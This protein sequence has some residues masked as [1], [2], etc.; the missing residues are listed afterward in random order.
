MTPKHD[1]R[2]NHLLRMLP[3]DEYQRLAPHLEPVELT[4]GQTLVESGRMT[5]YAYF[6]VNS[7]ISLLNIMEDGKT[8]EVSLVGMEGMVGLSLFMGGGSTPS[9]AI[10]Q[11][12]GT[13]Y[14]L[15]KQLLTDEFYRAGLLQ[16]MLLRFT[17]A[18]ITQMAHTAA[19]NRYHSVDQ[20]FCR[21]LLLTLDRL[22]TNK[23]IVTQGLIAN[24]LGVRRE[25]I[26]RSAHELKKAG[27][28]SYSRG[29]IH[30]LD[31]AGLEKRV[32]ECYSVVKKE[33][34]RLLPL[35]VPSQFRACHQASV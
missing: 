18:L 27:V 29:S 14:R 12:A 32:C 31:R 2:Q 13:A 20:Q 17:Q 23:L 19:C 22:P 11:N 5:R 10:V 24:I 35:P 9:S 3:Y 16:I 26:T 30:I 34:D 7:I 8:T 15:K 6:P 1:P 4:L 33:Y 25:G 28:I 21:W